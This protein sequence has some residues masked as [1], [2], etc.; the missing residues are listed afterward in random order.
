MKN[1]MKAALLA[2]MLFAAVSSMKALVS[3]GITIAPPPPPRVVRVL[4]PQPD[5][6]FIWV[7]GCWY[8]VGR[9]YVWHEGYWTRP[10]Y[11]G[12]PD[13][14]FSAT[15]NISCAYVTQKCVFVC[16]RSTS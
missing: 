10:P 4:E 16:P 13:T 6:D 11:E 5:P 15:G 8:P 14:A 3:I 1:L 12:A 7:E 2:A 9:H